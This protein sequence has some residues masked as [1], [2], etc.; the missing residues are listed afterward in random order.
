MAHLRLHA[1][2]SAFVL[3][4]VVAL[5]WTGSAAS[6]TS[7]CSVNI[8][9]HNAMPPE[10]DDPTTGG[11]ESTTITVSFDKSKVK[12]KNGFWKTLDYDSAQIDAG[13]TF[14]RTFKLAFGCGV[15]RRYKFYIREYL[16][17]GNY[18]SSKTVYFPGPNSWTTRQSFKV[19]LHIVPS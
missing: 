2:T 6:R 19:D 15:K 17:F 3:A 5:A 18:G 1:L 10:A 9:L 12:I 14:Q 13:E 8:K 4:L 11:L 16:G 7:G